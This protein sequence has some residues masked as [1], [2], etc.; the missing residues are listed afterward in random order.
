MILDRQPASTTR[1]DNPLIERGKP[2][3]DPIQA[4][5]SRVLGGKHPVVGQASG[6]APGSWVIRAH[7]QYFIVG[8]EL[9]AIIR[10]P[11]PSGEELIVHS[12]A[13]LV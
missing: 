5:L 6:N 13:R 7:G 10:L 12:A 2:L 4:C 1:A 8:H 11:L 3:H 9:G